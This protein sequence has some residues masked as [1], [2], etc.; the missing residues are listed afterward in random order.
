MDNDIIDAKSIDNDIIKN[1]DDNIMYNINNIMDEINNIDTYIEYIQYKLD[2]YYHVKNND[3]QRLIYNLNKK[4]KTIAVYNG[5]T[6]QFNNIGV[7]DV[8]GIRYIDFDDENWTLSNRGIDCN[9]RMTIF[10]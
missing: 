9:I 3:I 5:N 7:I 1:N 4:E 8:D 6:L 2:D 10:D